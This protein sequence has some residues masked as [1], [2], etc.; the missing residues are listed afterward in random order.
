MKKG[1]RPPTPYHTFDAA[2]LRSNSCPDEEGIK[3]PLMLLPPSTP[4]VRTLAL[5]KKG[6]RPTLTLLCRLHHRVRTLAL[7]KKGLRPAISWREVRF[8]VFE[9]LP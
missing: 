8:L 4:F 1:L 9:L 3:T 6:L 2:P 7:M 5:M